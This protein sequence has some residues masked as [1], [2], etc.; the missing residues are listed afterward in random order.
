MQDLKVSKIIQNAQQKF[1]GF[2]R[3]V[4]IYLSILNF[5]THTFR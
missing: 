5:W 2:N 1:V 3:Y 4:K